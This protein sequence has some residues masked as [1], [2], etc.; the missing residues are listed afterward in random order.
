MRRGRGRAGKYQPRKPG[1]GGGE[2]ALVR[3]R[4]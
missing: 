2:A 3:K 4:R 1:A